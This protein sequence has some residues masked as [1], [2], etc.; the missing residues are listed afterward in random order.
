MGADAQARVGIEKEV[1]GAEDGTCCQPEHD[2][3]R[4]LSLTR[5]ICP[6]GP[7]KGSRA[8]AHLP[9]L[10]VELGKPFNLI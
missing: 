1:R 2:A 9:V 3:L 6:V 8:Y 10:L 5:E 4:G 7:G